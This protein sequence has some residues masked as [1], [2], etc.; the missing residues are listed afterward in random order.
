M[1]TDEG[2]AEMRNRES[3]NGTRWGNGSAR[4]GVRGELGGYLPNGVGGIVPHIRA[5]VGEGIG[6]RWQSRRGITAIGCESPNCAQA[7]VFVKTRAGK[8]ACEGWHRDFWSV[9]VPAE[10]V[11]CCP[12]NVGVAVVCEK[13]DEDGANYIGGSC[14]RHS[15]DGV[16]GPSTEGVPCV[17]CCGEECG[18]RVS[19][20]PAQSH[21]RPEGG[22]WCVRVPHECS[23]IRRKGNCI[24]AEQAKRIWAGRGKLLGFWVGEWSHDSLERL[25]RPGF[26]LVERR[27]ALVLQ[28]FEQ[29]GK[30]VRSD[31]GDRFFGFFVLGV[32]DGFWRRAE[33][34]VAQGL[35]F[36]LWLGVVA[37]QEQGGD[38]KAR[39]DEGEEDVL[40]PHGGQCALSTLIS[41]LSTPLK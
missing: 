26:K 8:R 41:Q 29:E 13:P 7:G 2:K 15:G 14:A 6:Q 1:N 30:G 40:F 32:A 22:L 4:R 36:I 9:E 38:S 28:P 31:S 18:Q 11:G 16:C 25:W 21:D 35:A 27:R 3:R 20:D 37:C 12:R 17:F 23:E 33:N 34:P 24:R 19:S 5:W 10:P 39:A